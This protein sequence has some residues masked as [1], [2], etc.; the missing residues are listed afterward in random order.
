MA[1]FGCADSYDRSRRAPGPT[2]GDTDASSRYSGRDRAGF[3]VALRRASIKPWGA[4]ELRNVRPDLQEVKVEQGSIRRSAVSGFLEEAPGTAMTPEA[5]RR[6]A[7]LNSRSSSY[8]HGQANSRG[9][10]R[11]EPAPITRGLADR[12]S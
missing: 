12:Q 7:D 4:G 9:N 11:S 10:G 5:M 1:R 6:L 3:M 8:S 2:P